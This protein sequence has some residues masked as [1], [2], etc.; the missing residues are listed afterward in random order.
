MDGTHGYAG[1]EQVESWIRGTTMIRGGNKDHKNKV[2]GRVKKG[3]VL[4]IVS[5]SV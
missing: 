2:A 3:W 4:Q 1:P 5:R